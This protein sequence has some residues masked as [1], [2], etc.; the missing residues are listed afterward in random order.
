[1]YYYT[2]A[3]YITFVS[4]AVIS[5]PDD[6][7]V[8]EGRSTTF[9]CVLNGSMT[10]DDVQW[11]RLLKDTGTTEKL[12]TLKDSDFTVVPLPSM[13]NFTTMLYIANARKSYTGYYWVSSSLGDVCN[14]SFTVSTGILYV[15]YNVL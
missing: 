12:G 2:V 6:V 5:E 13:N 3:M 11:Y 8:C 14:T 15:V 9:T 10:S 4:T 7:T 1:M